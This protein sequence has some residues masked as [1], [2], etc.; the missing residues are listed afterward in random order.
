MEAGFKS[1]RRPRGRFSHRP[2]YSLRNFGGAM[3]TLCIALL[4][5]ILVGCGSSKPSYSGGDGSSPNE[6]VIIKKAKYHEA[7]VSA[8]RTWMEEHYPGY[9]KQSQALLSLG[10]KNY[11]VFTIRTKLSDKKVY[12]DITDFTGER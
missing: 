6:A 11:D 2:D 1:A 4:A 9:E 8:E 7:L 12:F 3:K 10:G 5:V